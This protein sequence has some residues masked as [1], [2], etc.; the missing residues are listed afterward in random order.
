MFLRPRFGATR[1][2]REQG[3]MRGALLALAVLA[4]AAVARPAAAET[5][6]F[7]AHLARDLDNPAQPAPSRGSVML[8][9]DTASKTVHWT[10]D[11]SGL[12]GPPQRLGCGALDAPGGPAIRVTKDLASPIRG[13]QALSDAEIGALKAGHWVC[14]IETGDDTTDIGGALQPAR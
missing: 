11:Y 2:T 10:V 9:L 7:T 8:S 4:G 6:Q 14:L 5:L 13:S 12:S 1:L 3:M